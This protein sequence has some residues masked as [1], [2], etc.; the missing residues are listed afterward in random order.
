MRYNDRREYLYDPEVFKRS[1]VA[2][3]LKIHDEYVRKLAGKP[4]VR[5]LEVDRSKAQVDP[6]WHQ[7]TSDVTQYSRVLEVP[8]IVQQE[9]MNWSLVRQGRIPQQRTKF[10][11]SNL[12]LKEL[13]YFP[14][15]GDFILWNGYRMELTAVE[16]EPNSYWQQTNVWLGI[17]YIGQIVP[18]GDARPSANMDAPAA[19]ELAPSAQVPFHTQPIDPTTKVDGRHPSLGLK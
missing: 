3:A 16:F 17:I 12:V 6:L 18:Y 11:T 14:L 5:F 15:Q 10:W 19:N 7:P 9:K 13:D 1:D 8:C 4:Y 2:I